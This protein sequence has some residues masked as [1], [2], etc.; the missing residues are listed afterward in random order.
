[1]L[2]NG[3][4]LAGV[5]V[6]QPETI[7]EAT[8]D[9]ARRYPEIDQVLNHPVRYGHGFQLARPGQRSVM[10]NGISPRAFGH[11]GSGVCNAWADPS[12]GLVV[13]Y[14]TNLAGPRTTAR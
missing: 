3:G 6:L 7:A 4:I 14:L 11:N 2:L 13:V 10:G 8:R 5:R 1:M 9:S 12:R